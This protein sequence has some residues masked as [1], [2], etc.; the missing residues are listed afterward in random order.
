MLFS[1]KQADWVRDLDSNIQIECIKDKV[2]YEEYLNRTE[3]KNISVKWRPNFDIPI[4]RSYALFDA[5][6]NNFKN[7]M[8]LDDDIKMTESNMQ[9]GLS[10]LTYNNSLVG[11]HVVDYPDVSTI[12]HI[13][14]IITKNSNVI[15]MTGSCMFIDV[16]KVTGDFP[17]IYNEDLFFFMKQVNP[18]KI[19]SGGTILQKDYQSWVFQDRVMHEQ[20]G[21]LIYEAFKK[22]FI[23]IDR[24]TIDW[25]K[26]IQLRLNKIRLL[27]SETSQEVLGEAL[28]IAY[29][30]T[31]AIRVSDINRFIS[32]YEFAN[33]TSKYL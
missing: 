16:E 19:V 11:F 9:A 32:N 6:N 10:V 3:N 23:G 8:L 33:W 22:R 1:E 21:D 30:G 29:Y 18:L 7:I 31:S 25:E 14:R 12:D 27:M 26:E 13:E 28:K 15:S 4:K 24:S 2:F 5:R 20:F 17:L